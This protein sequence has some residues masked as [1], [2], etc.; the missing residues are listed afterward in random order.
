VIARVVL[1]ILRGIA[2][3]YNRRHPTPP[4]IFKTKAAAR[5]VGTDSFPLLRFR[6]IRSEMNALSHYRIKPKPIDPSVNP[7][8]IPG[9]KVEVASTPSD[10]IFSSTDEAESLP[11]QAVANMRIGAIMPLNGTSQLTVDGQ[12][13][14]QGGSLKQSSLPG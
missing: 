3:A 5:T 8:R 2:A 12:L 10:P 11:N 9:S 6:G 1:S 4:S 7:F 13:Y 14:K